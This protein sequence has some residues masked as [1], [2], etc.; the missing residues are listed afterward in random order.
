MVPS[1]APGS[2]TEDLPA[3]IATMSVKGHTVV[4]ARE[5]G[6]L[7]WE[8]HYA[9]LGA[10]PPHTPALGPCTSRSRVTEHS[11]S[12]D[13]SLRYQNYPVKPRGGDCFFKCIDTYARL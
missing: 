1:A 6:G 4:S 3:L 2:D 10:V 5:L 11:Q 12:T 7:S 13:K 8:R 9:P